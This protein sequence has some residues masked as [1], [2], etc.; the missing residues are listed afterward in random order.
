MSEPKPACGPHTELVKTD[1]VRVTQCSC[2]TIHVTL[3]KNG[4]T[5]QLPPEYFNEV[6]QSLGLARTVLAGKNPVQDR[7][8]TSANA[9]R[10]VTLAPFDPKKP[11]N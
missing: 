11:A 10:F 6:A 1:G 9:G 8:A 7:P 3:F 2:G 4:T 5:I